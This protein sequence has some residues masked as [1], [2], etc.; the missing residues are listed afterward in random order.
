MATNK[1]ELRSTIVR[2]S[3][4]LASSTSV[5]QHKHLIGRQQ[6][7]S[8]GFFFQK[9]NARCIDAYRASD[10]EARCRGC[11]VA[12]AARIFARVTPRARAPI[13][14]GAAYIRQASTLI[15]AAAIDKRAKKKNIRVRAHVYWRSCARSAHSAT[16]AVAAVA[17]AAVWWRRACGQKGG[18]RSSTIFSR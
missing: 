12:A 6:V 8:I 10:D 17:A 4:H 18:A 1:R 9:A 13:V 14:D 3:L 16:I 15:K 7:C 2:P 5:K 11:A